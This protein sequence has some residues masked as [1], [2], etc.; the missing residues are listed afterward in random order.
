MPNGEDPG[1]A[2]ESDG[3]GGETHEFTTANEDATLESSAQQ[4]ARG[5]L[6]PGQAG[7][8]PVG[9]GSGSATFGE[10]TAA[11][12]DAA[13]NAMTDSLPAGAGDSHGS[14]SLQGG[15][16][17]FV[18]PPTEGSSH[19]SLYEPIPAPPEDPGAL[20]GEHGYATSP[21]EGS[22]QGSLYEPIPAPR[23]DPGAITGEHD[24]VTSPTEGSS[25]GSLHE[26][27]PAPREDPGA[28]TGEHDYVTSPSSS[29]GSSL[30]SEYDLAPE[31]PRKYSSDSL[32]PEADLL[33]EK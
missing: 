3:R 27:I 17:D 15:E 10:N 1:K 14:G 23:E 33:K 24:Y 20:T 6:N 4:Q 12:L 19:S 29:G 30:H 2:P 21:A 9:D 11:L 32:R 7:L 28:L 18:T 16:H 5:N 25:H 8:G 13:L 22:S 26:P 31:P